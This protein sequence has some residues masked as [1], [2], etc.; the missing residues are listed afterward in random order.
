MSGSIRLTQDASPMESVTTRL[1]FRAS[2]EDVWR[3]LMFYEDVPQRPRTLLRLLLPMPVNSQGNKLSVGATVRCQYTR[4]HLLKLITTVEPARL[5]AFEVLE[6]QLGIE[7]Y[8]R[9]CEGSYRFAAT[10]G[11]TE[12]ALTTRYLGRLWPRFLW[13]QLERQ[14]CH[15]VHFH[16]LFGML[17]RLAAPLALSAATV[18]DEAPADSAQPLTR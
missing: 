1:H 2:P 5:L 15:R 12:L 16:I 7:R 17:D 9:A 8:A 3:C 11:G 6:Q 13:R 10:D 4:G 18:P 14:L